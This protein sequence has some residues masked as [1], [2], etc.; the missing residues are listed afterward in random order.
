M[1]WSLMMLVG[2]VIG[3]CGTAEKKT[4]KPGDRSGG[5]YQDDGPGDT[6]PESLAAIADAVPRDEPPHRFANRPYQVFGRTYVP[7]LAQDAYRER[8]VASW[9]GRKFHGQKTASGE[10]YDMYAMTAAHKTLPI[11]S[12]VRVSNP[13]NGRAVVVRVNDRGPFHGDRLIDLS[14]TAAAKIGIVNAGSAVVDVERVFAR[15]PLANPSRPSTPAPSLPVSP[16]RTATPATP[17]PATREVVSHDE[18]GFYLQLGAFAS[19][20]N[21][22]AMLERTTRELTWLAEPLTIVESAGLHRVRLGPYRQRVEVDAIATQIEKSL[23][24]PPTVVPARP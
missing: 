21:A 1:R 20:D 9:Y 10:V 7:V 8:G 3:A 14:W 23:G 22:Q 13:A 15:S 11:P 24:F 2:L 5:Y 6:P 18:R 17:L 12:Y 4:T 19:R 16:P